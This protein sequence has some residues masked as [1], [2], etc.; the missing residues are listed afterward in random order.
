M[1]PIIQT[2][3]VMYTVKDL[4]HTLNTRDGTAGGGA[5]RPRTPF[6]DRGVHFVGVGG[7]G[8]S[9]LAHMLINFGA[10]VSGTDRS[11]SA[12]TRRLS[13]V[14]A[15]IAYA[16]TADTL[17]PGTEIVVHSDEAAHWLPDEALSKA[18]QEAKG[19]FEGARNAVAPYAGRMRE[20]RVGCGELDE[21]PGAKDRD[22]IGHLHRF[23]D[24]VTHE[25]DRL[26]QRPLR[27]L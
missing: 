2:K 25:K 5:H 19:Y 11:P 3:A 13:E 16:E 20:H 15:A 4:L 6:T 24:V 17:P 1:P 27:C 9:G 8:M 23:V 12:V 18:P 26:L 14:G 22:S 10:R 7:S 21:A